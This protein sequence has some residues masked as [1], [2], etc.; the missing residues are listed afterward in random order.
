MKVVSSFLGIKKHPRSVVALGVFDGVHL[1][2]RRIL[3]DVVKKARAIKAKSVAVTFWPHP[4]KKE[5]LYSL[6]HRIN[7]I[8]ELGID[9]CVV[10]KFASNF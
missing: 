7:L 10:I 5:T 9:I 2:H 8:S 6:E 1:A 3:Q 4:Q